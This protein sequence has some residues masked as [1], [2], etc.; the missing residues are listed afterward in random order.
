[1]QP[2]G[3]IILL[4]KNLMVLEEGAIEGRIT[5]GNIIKYIKM[6]DGWTFGNMFS[7]RWLSRHFP[8]STFT[9]R[10]ASRPIYLA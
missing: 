9:R 4:E 3:S 6:T 8:V 10:K 5:F 2:Y 7:V 1:V